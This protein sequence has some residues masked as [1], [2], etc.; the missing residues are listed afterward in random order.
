MQDKLSK[1]LTISSPHTNPTHRTISFTSSYNLN[2][3]PNPNLNNLRI[4]IKQIGIN[5]IVI[6]WL[7]SI[8]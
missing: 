8:A 2:L 1:I 7:Y 3:N 6:V 5:I 4:F